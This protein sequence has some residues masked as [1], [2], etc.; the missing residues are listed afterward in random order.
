MLSKGF[1][2]VLILISDLWATTA[3]G[4]LTLNTKKPQQPEHLP[5]SL[6]FTHNARKYLPTENKG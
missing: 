4:L 3:I 6:L 5:N 2:T 1:R